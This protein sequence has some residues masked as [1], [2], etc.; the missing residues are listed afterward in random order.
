MSFTQSALRT[1]YR[2]AT[3]GN[4]LRSG[5]LNTRNV[6]AS[7]GGVVNEQYP[8]GNFPVPTVSKGNSKLFVATFYWGACSVAFAVPFIALYWANSGKKD[9]E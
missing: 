5:R 3:R 6:F 7:R 8:G 1:S 2:F 9:E 4:A